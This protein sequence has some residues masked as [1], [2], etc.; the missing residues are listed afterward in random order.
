MRVFNKRFTNEHG[1][2]PAYDPKIMLKIVIYGY[3]R[4]ILSSREIEAACQQNVIFMALSANTRPHFTTIAQFIASMRDV[5]T[6][7][8]RDVLMYCDELGLIGKEMFAIDGCRISSNASK[9]WSGTREDFQRKKKKI[10]GSVAFLL[11]KHRATDEK[12]GPGTYD[13]M[14]QKEKKALEN[15]K[16]K[17]E[18]ID[19]WLKEN[20]EDRKG[21]R[22]QPIKSS[23]T[24]S[25]SA[26]MKGSHG[27]VQ[28]Y[29]GMAAVDEKHQVIVEAQ[30]EGKS[31]E[32]GALEPMV[33]GTKANFQH[34]GEEDLFHQWTVTADSG[35]SSND[36]MEYLW[37]NKIPGYVADPGF[38]KRDPRFDT[39]GRHKKP[40][41]RYKGKKSQR[42]YFAPK[43]FVLNPKTG[44]LVCPAGKELYVKNRNFKTANGFYGVSYMAKITDCRECTIRT[45]CLRLSHTKARQVSKF[46]KRI[47]PQNFS[48]W[49]R[50]RFDSFT[51]RHSYSRRMGT[52]EPVFANITRMLGLD[53]FTLRGKEKV[54]AQWKLFCMVHNLTKIQRYG[55]VGAA[56]G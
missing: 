49:M 13:T 39:A 17:V 40:I 36:N 18:K 53:R 38:R 22:G 12:E 10:E 46:Y 56:A 35:F 14:R 31:S 3:S 23:M 25:D 42:K 32:R 55:L 7:L 43:D 2:R 44:K 30:A 4:G 41:D 51:G 11:N 54:N 21:T 47:M 16:A 15:L 34:V 26:K 27:V 20:T 48:Q 1:G 6:P 8:F 5:I 37:K 33:E 28:G 19:K 52:V 24:D 50:E 9:E 29:N 45:K